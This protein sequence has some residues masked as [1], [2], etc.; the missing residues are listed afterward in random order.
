MLVELSAFLVGSKLSAGE[1]GW[2]G[3]THMDNPNP[4]LGSPWVMLCG[5]DAD[6]H[7]VDRH[8][9]QLGR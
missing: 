6:L 4:Q 8:S 3:K 2:R 5:H 7:L 9:S 1:K